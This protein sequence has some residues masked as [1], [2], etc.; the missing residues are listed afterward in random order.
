[1][2]ESTFLA[3]LAHAPHLIPVEFPS[4]VWTVTHTDVNHKRALV[5]AHLRWS[6]HNSK[7]KWATAFTSRGR[8]VYAC[9]DRNLMSGHVANKA[10][11]FAQYATQR[12]FFIPQGR[13]LLR[14]DADTGFRKV[15]Y[16]LPKGWKRGFYIDHPDVLAYWDLVHSKEMPAEILWDMCE[17]LGLV[18]PGAEEKHKSTCVPVV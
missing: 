14:L 15:I 7:I 16:C 2:N 4:K 9:R 8:F 18:Q 10:K 6:V 11:Y 3:Y 5:C 1:M 13:F 17:E 12:R